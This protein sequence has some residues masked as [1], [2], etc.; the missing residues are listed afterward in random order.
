MKHI[1]VPS[2]LAAPAWALEGPLH[3][4]RQGSLEAGGRLVHGPHNDGGDPASKRWPAGLVHVGQVH[5]SYQYPVA[6][7]CPY[8]VLLHPGGGH[9][10]RVYDTTPDGR[11]G[12]LTQFLRRGFAV[13]GVDWPNSGRSG[14][15]IR[16]IN[17]VRLG[18][19]P[20]E[21][22]PAINR[23]PAESAWVTFRWGPAFGEPFHD[24]QFPVDCA[25][26]YYP[27]LLPTYRGPSEIPDAVAGFTA[28][29]D[30]VGPS[31]LLTWS[32]SGLPGY[33]VAAQ[34][35][36]LVKAV[37]AV[38]TSVTAYDNI[39]AGA[40]ARLA[41][42]PILSLIGDRAPDRVEASLGFR[43]RLRELGGEVAV[44]YLPDAGIHGNGHAL[45]LEKNNVQILERI[46]AWMERN[47]PGALP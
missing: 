10:A 31:I 18:H 38:E 12:W 3:I 4:A 15:D 27:Q 5:A 20:A 42:I 39:P 25:A 30:K 8:P 16:Q 2:P 45:M 7:R 11:E 47:V 33:L 29:L 32:A 35:P 43:R 28:M 19:E 40:L 21:S 14:G 13:Y 34:R 41:G 9:S 1:D 46:V 24:T 37:V 23:Y 36:E 26:D 22:L 17:A 6:Q 44:D